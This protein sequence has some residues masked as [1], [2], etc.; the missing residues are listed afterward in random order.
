MNEQNTALTTIQTHEQIGQLANQYAA[1]SVF[2]NY[3]DKQAHN[4][5]RRH[6]TDL[7]LFS[8]Y[9]S[10][11]GMNIETNELLNS[12]D[13]WKHITH[14]LVEGFV[15]WMIREGYSIG[16]VNVRLFTVRLYCKLSVK[17]DA[18]MRVSMLV[19]VWYRGTVL[20]REDT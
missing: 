11:A 5:R 17:A 18:R 6:Q 20:L 16:S 1:Q 4:T 10:N 13:A 14:G 7:A 3:Q 15:Q 2:Q 12:P 19:S 9:L 8:Q